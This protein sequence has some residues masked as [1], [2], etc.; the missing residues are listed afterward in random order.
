MQRTKSKILSIL[1]SLVMLLSLLPTTAL[2]ANYYDKVKVNGIL[3]Q[4]GYYLETNS[5]TSAETG[6]NTEPTTYV[7][8]YKDGVLTLN[9][10]TGKDDYGIETQGVA[11]G[12]LTVKLIGSNSINNGALVSDNGGDITVTSDSSGTLSISK[13]TSGSNPAIGIETGLSGSYTTGNVTIKGNAKVTINMT[14]N[15]TRTYERAYGIYAKENITISENASVDITCAT[16]NNTT[17]GGNC[18]GLYPAK[19]VTIDTNGTIKIDVTNAGKDKDNGYSY[20]V[21]QMGNA[22]LTKVG[23]MEVQWKKVG[24]NT[25]YSG[26]AFFRGETFSDTDHAINENTTN[27]YAS[28]RYGTSYYTVTAENG[29]L[30]GPGVKYPNGNGKFLAGD[31][32]NITPATKEGRSGEEIPF[33]EWTSSDV[34][35]DKSATTASNSFTVPGKD[36]TVTAKH[37]PFVGTPTFTPIGTT[38]TKGTL[39]FKTVVKADAAYEGFRLVKEGNE[40]NESSYNLINP[41]MTSISSPYEYSCETSIYEL[42]ECNYYVAEYLNGKYYLSDKFTVSY[43]AAPT[44]TANI[45]LDKTGTVDFG[46]AEAGYSTAPAAQ[47]VTITNNGTAATGTL[48]IALDGAN[49]S[50]FTLST[51]SIADIAASGGTGTFTVQ[52]NT[53]LS[54]GIYTATVKVSGTGAGV[55][56]QSFN[57]KFTVTDPA[58]PIAAP[59]ANTGLVYDGTEKTGVTES[60]GYTL[61]G[62]YKA[63]DVGTANYTA[64]ATLNPGYTWNDGSIGVKTITWNI[65]KRTPTATDFNF[66]APAD[67]IYDGNDK[68]AS[69]TLKSPFT[70]SGAI[71]PTYMKGSSVVTETKDV[72]TYTVKIDV[73]GGGNFNAGSNLND[74]AWTFSITPANQSAP[75][76]L[77]VAAP[78]ASGG[79]GKITGTTTAMEYSTDSNFASPAGTPCTDTATEVAPATYYVRLKADA[80]HNAGTVSA[81]LVVPGYSATKYTVSVTSDA[82]GTAIA[83][84]TADVAA[85]ETVTLTASPNSGYVFDEWVEKNPTSLSIGTDGKFTMPSENVSVK[86]T[87]KGAALTGT[88]NI[89][90][91]LKYG[92]ELT[93]TL[94]GGNNTGTLT[95]KWYRSG[96]TTEIATNNTGKYTLR[97]E[98][99]GKTITVK[100]SSDV[101]TGEIPSSATGTIDRADGPAAPT[102]FTLSFTL[103]SDGTTFTATI[104]AFAGGEYSFDGMTYS[105]TNTKTDCAANTSYTGYARVKETAT[106]KTGTESS[107]TQTSPKLT[108]ATPT[109]TPNGASSFTG[110][111]SV[112]I[113]CTTAGA[114]IYYTTDGTTPT[115]SSTEYTTALSLT[116]TTTVKAIAVKAGMND[117]ATATATFT[118][119]SG[120]GGGGGGSYTP[121]YTVSVDKTENGTI[122]VS[123]KSASKGDAVTITVTPDKGYELEDL[124]VLDSKGKELALTEKNGKYSFK[125]PAGKVEVKATFIKEAEISPFDDVSTNAYYYEAVK[126]AQEKGITGGIGNKL[127]GPNDPCT[128]AQIVTFLWRAAGSP[129][130]KNTGTAFGDVK[131]GSFYEQAVAW[132]VENGITGGTGDGKFSPDATCTRAQSVTFLYRAAGSPAVS[133]SAEFGDVATNAYYA[134]AVAWAAKNGITGGIGGG[135]FGS[136]NDCTRAQIVTFLYRNYQSK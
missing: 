74:P 19:D 42:D 38:G 18:N 5:S 111:Q 55:T 107:D 21:Y 73:A 17:G 26:G 83:D 47:T 34:M 16:P 59:T 91:T 115:A 101:Q 41:D 95:Y 93:A 57:V 94:T 97:A 110:T 128:R 3:L 133:G 10:F 62:T 104:P 64:T 119:Y 13:T 56:E 37:S 46:S 125:M 92:Q 81:A 114:K 121:S 84:K 85:G 35:L 130:P 78:T 109:F 123:P 75:T 29:K 135:L 80:N 69:V 106:H 43:T 132:A 2:A 113:S 44:P 1:L 90:G 77:G 67:L 120:G 96:E 11:A 79:N 126:W 23:N 49:A 48:T 87:F 15:G 108:V 24:N 117:S 116:S 14:H 9:N 4:N 105:T 58:T 32:V 45:S 82:N 27:C 65:D 36:V 88:V 112:T 39:T 33:K 99:I 66:T 68:T 129:A 122:T 72:G 8:W 71:T 86:A 50:S 100:V 51:A 52:P 6:A 127:F 89:T 76:G 54:A 25:L 12:E 118:K 53:G 7:A 22:T 40:N 60:A 103:N 31:K 102:A 63:T 28:Y 134:D 98:D 124:T 70:N 20:G 61:T 136:G 30:T 131:P